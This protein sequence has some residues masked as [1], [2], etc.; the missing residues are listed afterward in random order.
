MIREKSFGSSDQSSVSREE[1]LKFWLV[2]G[3]N[4]G[5]SLGSQSSSTPS[6]FA[7]A[8]GPD[9][10][11]D[12]AAAVTQDPEPIE[13]VTQ[14]IADLHEELAV[15]IVELQSLDAQGVLKQIPRDDN[16]K[17]SSVGSITHTAGECSPCLF[18]KRNCCSKGILCQ[19]C[20]LPHEDSRKKSKPPKKKEGG[21]ASKDPSTSARGLKT[22]KISL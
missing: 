19:Y 18:L 1:V 11:A 22:H 21:Q 8:M 14:Y 5:K 9:W 3:S 12:Q 2:G 7:T 17:L 4:G 15:P 20:H 10:E 16:G 13:P 6:S